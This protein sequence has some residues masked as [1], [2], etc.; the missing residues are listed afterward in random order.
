MGN[1][2]LS[3]YRAISLWRHWTENPGQFADLKNLM[4]AVNEESDI[5][6]PLIST[7][8]YADTRPADLM[9]IGSLQRS[10]MGNASDRRIDIRFTLIS[11]KKKDVGESKILSELIQSK[12]NDQRKK[13]ESVK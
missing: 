5:K 7:S 11:S 8:G 10:I 2:G 12:L 9:S 1:W 4:T 13:L 3:T 6:R